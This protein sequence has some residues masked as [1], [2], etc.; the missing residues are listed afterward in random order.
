MSMNYVYKWLPTDIVSKWLTHGISFS[1]VHTFTDKTE[2]SVKYRP[3]RANELKQFVDDFN[4]K[5]NEQNSDHHNI[6][7]LLEH[8][9]TTKK[10]LDKLDAYGKKYA[11]WVRQSLSERYYV[12]CL[13]AS[14]KTDFKW[15][16]SNGNSQSR[17]VFNK[18]AL[19]DYFARMMRPVEYFDHRPYTN[20]TDD[21]ETSVYKVIF[22]KLKKGTNGDN[23]EEESEI[24]IA[25]CIDIMK[26]LCTVHLHHPEKDL[27][28]IYDRSLHNFL[29]RI[30]TP[31]STPSELKNEWNEIIHEKP[32][33]KANFERWE[34]IMPIDVNLLSKFV[35]DTDL[36]H[37]LAFNEENL[38]F[39]EIVFRDVLRTLHETQC[40]YP[41]GIA[42]KM[43]I[44][45][46]TRV[47]TYQELQH[48]FE[49]ERFSNDVYINSMPGNLT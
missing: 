44:S 36:K 24:R 27:P 22:S 20:Q 1:P 6:K 45:F 12:C 47:P 48:L 11:N 32:N 10:L 21:L 3:L 46:A 2:F 29:V 35:C 14:D 7:S 25:C 19:Q 41:D 49:T 17:L 42:E 38:N 13:T 39:D 37:K 15:S 5:Y 18:D 43:L 9:S 34:K 26:S 4:T 8:P 30:D 28:Y 33:A 31:D 16:D 40:L 23:Y